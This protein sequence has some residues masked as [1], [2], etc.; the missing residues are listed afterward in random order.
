[1]IGGGEKMQRRFY[2][3]VKGHEL[4]FLISKHDAAPGLVVAI[5]DFSS[6]LD[7]SGKMCKDSGNM[8]V[9]RLVLDDNFNEDV[10]R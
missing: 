10:F 9:P 8:I 5:S 7:D 2:G 3:P 6:F 1:M 4:T